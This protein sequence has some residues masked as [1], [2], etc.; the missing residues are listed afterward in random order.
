MMFAH[1]LPTCHAPRTLYA[2]IS[3]ITFSKTTVATTTTLT[4]GG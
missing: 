1:S 2:V 3:V 4:K